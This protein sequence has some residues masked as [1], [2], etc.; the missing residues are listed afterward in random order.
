MEIPEPE[1][2]KVI[3][4]VGLAVPI[5]TFPVT[6]NLPVMFS[7][8][9]TVRAAHDTFKLLF[10]VTES[11]IPSGLLFSIPTRVMAVSFTVTRALL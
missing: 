10:P 4:W 5:P 8:P 11:T 7:F 9:V 1:L 6:A 3:D 2:A